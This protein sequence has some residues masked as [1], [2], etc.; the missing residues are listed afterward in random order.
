MKTEY[1]IK[2]MKIIIQ[3]KISK[4]QI[5]A[6]NAW[7]ASDEVV[8]LHYDREYTKLIAQYNI[9]YEVLR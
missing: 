2:D 8:Y 6:Q 9:L 4:V 3:E 5:Q 1:Q 7:D